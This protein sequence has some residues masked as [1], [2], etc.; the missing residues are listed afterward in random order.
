MA[1]FNPIDYSSGNGFGQGLQ[2]AGLYQQTQ[3]Q[4]LEAE[5]AQ[6]QQAAMQAFQKDWQT[7][8]SS[9]DPKQLDA[10]VAKYPGQMETV[11]KA[12]GFRDDNHR[13]ALGNAARDLR[14]AM[15]SGNPEAVAMAA[16]THADTLG[17][18]GATPQEIMQQFQQDPKGLLQTVDTVGMGALGVKDYFGVQNDQAQRQIQR[19][20]LAETIRSNKAGEGLQ[21]QGQNLSYS[22]QMARLNHDKMVYKQSQAA[23]NKADAAGEIDAYKLNAQ[24]ASTGMD[25]LT[26]KPATGARFNAA[27]RWLE[28]NQGFNEALIT[29]Q[30]GIEKING[31]LANEK[32]EGVG[33][34][35]GRIPEIGLSDAGIQ[36]RNSIEELKSGAFVQN[37]QMLKGMGALSNAEGE[38]LQNLI[39][40][41]DVTQP[42]EVVRKQLGEIR[43]QYATL[44]R[45]SEAEAAAM[46]YSSQGFDTYVQERQ[47]P[48]A[49]SQS[50]A[51]TQQ[52]TGTYTSQS[53][54]KFEVK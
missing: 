15:S 54:I 41:L 19:D 29:G 20:Q 32:L 44:Q 40:K 49:E 23:I 47:K 7:A 12:I 8:Y 26:G 25:P 45:V 21:A 38:K 48:A 22:A 16:Q 46:G 10:I 4:R 33:K 42:E 28:G 3:Q 24:I 34:F 30:R 43:S 31:L 53:G 39:S 52:A 6:Q 37:V 35:A 1:E 50:G 11:Q 18:V 13:M 36:S 17:S 51:P 14:V 5:Q 27:K 9:G 2:L